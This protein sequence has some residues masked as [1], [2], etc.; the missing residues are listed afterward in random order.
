MN[1]NNQDQNYQLQ[2]QPQTDLQNPQP[3]GHT[4]THIIVGSLVFA[5]LLAAVC[6]YSINSTPASNSALIEQGVTINQTLREAKISYFNLKVII[7]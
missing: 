5:V 6:I 2:N 7:K 3:T 1:P 4:K